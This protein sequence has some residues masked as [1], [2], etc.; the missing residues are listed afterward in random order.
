MN[1][2]LTLSTALLSTDLQND[3]LSPQDVIWG[4]V[5]K[6]VTTTVTTTTP[7]KKSTAV[8]NSPTSQLNKELS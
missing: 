5:G 4:I 3:F 7:S 6:S 8:S 1:S 2:K